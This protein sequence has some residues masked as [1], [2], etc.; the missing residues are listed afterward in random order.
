MAVQLPTQSPQ[1]LA[2]QNVP[3]IANN[4][5]PN[6]VYNTPQ[7]AW[8]AT[9]GWNTTTVTPAANFMPMQMPQFNLGLPPGQPMGP[10]A[11]L[12]NGWDTPTGNGGGPMPPV[13]QPPVQPPTQPPV[14]PPTGDPPPTGRP[15]QTGGRGDGSLAGYGGTIYDDLTGGYGGTWKPSTVPTV[16][17]NQDPK[18]NGKGSGID[19]PNG[20][21]FG[22]IP[23]GGFGDWLHDTLPG[24]AGKLGFKED[25]SI[26]GAQIL[27]WFI[28]GNAYNNG[29][30]NLGN[31]FLGALSKF[32]G[33]PLKTLT[34]AIANSKFIQNS[35]SAVARMLKNWDAKNDAMAARD[36][37]AA[38]DPRGQWGN[39][40]PNVGG[41]DQPVSDPF[42]PNP[43]FGLGDNDVGVEGG[44]GDGWGESWGGNLPQAPG[45]TGG[46][47]VYGGSGIGGSGF[48]VAGQLDINNS[49]GN[50]NAGT[51][52]RDDVNRGMKLLNAMNRRDIRM[53]K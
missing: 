3:G 9:G 13:V 35:D 20:L 33:L 31:A 19:L 15:P 7:G 5:N 40:A 46:S 2:Q 22:N 42:A 14:T 48:G 36:W 24:V 50:G 51:F 41:W 37:N 49:S 18:Y 4:G 30:W 53:R 26:D 16:H 27:D 38:H 10:I 32:T 11:V 34:N 1:Q 29:E 25:G 21:S 45:L 43:G 12:P 39:F 52:M 23:L 6:T 28:P 8:G 47:G 44:L 17:P